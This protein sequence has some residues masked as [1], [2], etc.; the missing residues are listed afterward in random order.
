MKRVCRVASS[1]W[2]SFTN[3]TSSIYLSPNNEIQVVKQLN[4]EPWRQW[5]TALWLVWCS[6]GPLKCIF[7]MSNFCMFYWL[8]SPD[9]K[10]R[11]VSQNR[12]NHDA[13]RICRSLHFEWLQVF[14]YNPMNVLMA[15]SYK[16]CEPCTGWSSLASAAVHRNWRKG[17]P[18]DWGGLVPN[19]SSVFV[20]GSNDDL[21]HREH[22]ASMSESGSI[23]SM[24]L[25][26]SP[27]RTDRCGVTRFNM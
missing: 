16:Q 14:L 2:F 1:V 23:R 17:H 24:K 25:E 21:A 22:G 26:V 11:V 27:S 8:S 5:C 3:R 7:F 12:M 13:S 10:K 19:W 18:V 4:G 15:P 9:A 20:D 6:L